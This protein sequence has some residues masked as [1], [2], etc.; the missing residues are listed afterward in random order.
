MPP[1]NKDHAK[2]I[3]R[4]VNDKSK[5]LGAITDTDQRLTIWFVSITKEFGSLP[6]ALGAALIAISRTATYPMNCI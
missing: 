5:R 2:A 4:K 6:L 1:I 3:A